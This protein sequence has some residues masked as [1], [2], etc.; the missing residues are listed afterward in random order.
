MS[1]RCK[2]REKYDRDTD[3]DGLPDDFEWAIGTSP[4]AQNTD[5]DEETDAVEYVRGRDPTAPGR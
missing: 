5:G 1:V 4:Y 3:F 2:V